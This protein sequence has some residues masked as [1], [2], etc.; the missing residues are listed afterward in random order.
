MH[1]IIERIYRP[2]SNVEIINL[3]KTCDTCQKIK[4]EQK[5]KL[6]KMLLHSKP[7]QLITTDIGSPLKETT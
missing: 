3:V 6:A 2:K 5:K 4:R 7:N 1:K